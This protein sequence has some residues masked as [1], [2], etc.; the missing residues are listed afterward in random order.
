MRHRTPRK[1][2]RAAEAFKILQTLHDTFF[3]SVGDGVEEVMVARV[4]ARVHHGASDT[5]HGGTSVL[6]LD[7]KCAV[8]FIG[9]LDLGSEGV[10]SGDGPGRSIV[11]SWKVLWTSSVLSG[12]HGDG[13][14]NCSEKSDLGQ[15]QSRDVGKSG[16]AHTVL[17]DGVKRSFSGKIHRSWEGNVE[18]LD[19]H[20]DEG[21]HGDTS[22]LDLDGTAT[23]EGVGI[24]SKT[25]R[26][27]M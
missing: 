18:L 27:P 21:S 8:T 20:T 14:S 23:G 1:K 15:A 10:S 19:Q 5:K 3:L 4:K 22:V 26:I 9:V 24:L 13:L 17:H 6:D 12:G 11:T 16:E 25:K 7:I 2:A